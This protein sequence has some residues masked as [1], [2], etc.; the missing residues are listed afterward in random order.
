MQIAIL[1]LKV[2][3]INFD[4]KNWFEYNNR[5]SLAHQSN[6]YT[7]FDAKECQEVNA[8]KIY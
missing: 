3:K 6:T 2:L 7:E 5:F 4:H 8:L 1:P